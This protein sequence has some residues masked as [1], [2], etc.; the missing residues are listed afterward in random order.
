MRQAEDA[1]LTAP[2][3]PTK[4]LSAAGIPAPYN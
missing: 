2:S 4:E 1:G 3:A